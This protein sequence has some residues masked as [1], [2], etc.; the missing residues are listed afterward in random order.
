M[1]GVRLERLVVG[2]VI[3]R[4][5][6]PSSLSAQMAAPRLVGSATAERMM[7]RPRTSARICVQRS[8]RWSAP[9]GDVDDVRFADDGHQQVVDGSQ[10]VSHGFD[11]RKQKVGG[12]GVETRAV[13]GGAAA[14][15]QP[16]LRSPARK[17]NTVRPWPS[18]DKSAMTSSGSSPRTPRRRS[19]SQAATVA[20]VAL[21]AAQQ[22][23]RPI[24]AVLPQAGGDRANR[25]GNQGADARWFRC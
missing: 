6:C 8:E 24:D 5:G 4:A 15:S 16:G 21:S 25:T 11:A 22:R 10:A 17:G 14:S 13:D 20:A 9:P 1:G 7:G 3:G 23:A 12:L 2:A 18:G 19:R